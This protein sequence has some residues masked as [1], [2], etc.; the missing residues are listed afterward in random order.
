MIDFFL[1]DNI[2]RVIHFHNP[3]LNFSFS[4]LFL[5]CLA[6]LPLTAMT[7]ELAIVS[8]PANLFYRIDKM[9]FTLYIK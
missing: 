9:F 6:R 3:F 7:T 5:L 4:V 1:L 8:L 2:I